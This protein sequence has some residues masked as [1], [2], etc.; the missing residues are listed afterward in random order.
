VSDLDDAYHALQVVDAAQV[1]AEQGKRI[2]L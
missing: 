1:S 2:S